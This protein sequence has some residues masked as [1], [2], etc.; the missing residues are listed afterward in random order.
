MNDC[1]TTRYSQKCQQW[2]RSLYLVNPLL[3]ASPLQAANERLCDGVALA[4]TAVAHAR[5][6]SV[7]SVTSLT[8]EL[9]ALAGVNDFPRG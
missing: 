4:I 9:T 6:E 2:P 1:R 5:F 8:I 7:G 3:D